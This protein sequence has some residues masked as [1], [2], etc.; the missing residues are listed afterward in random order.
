MPIG[1]LLLFERRFAYGWS[2]R[3]RQVLTPKSRLS[4]QYLT[5]AVNSAP[6]P[7]TIATIRQPVLSITVKPAMSATSP[8][9]T[10]VTR[11]PPPTLCVMVLLS[12]FDFRSPGRSSASFRPSDHSATAS[13]RG[14]CAARPPTSPLRRRAGWNQIHAAFRTLTRPVLP[15]FRVHGT[16]VGHVAGRRSENGV[17]NDRMLDIGR[18]HGGQ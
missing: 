5:K 8:I 9:T 2:L 18:A 12:F 10:R 14:S 3:W 7:T 16:R 6:A 1:M 15:D 11:S 17:A 4:G 13:G